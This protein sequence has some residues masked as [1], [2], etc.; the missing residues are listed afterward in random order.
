MAED[1]VHINI[2][3]SFIR[4]FDLK[5]R[6][7][8]KGFLTGISAYSL[9][10]EHEL[11]DTTRII[12]YSQIKKIKTKR[13]SGANY[14]LGSVVGVS[15]GFSLIV[16]DP[17]FGFPS[18]YSGPERI[19][20]ISVGLMAGFLGGIFYDLFKKREVYRIEGNHDNFLKLF[21]ELA[22]ANQVEILSE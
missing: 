11:K 15:L 1:S 21:Q 17:D 8:D 14:L 22:M 5:N 6:K 10:L 13:S 12:H 20:A 4:I 2:K 7:T 9:K 16:G 18:V 19:A 3:R